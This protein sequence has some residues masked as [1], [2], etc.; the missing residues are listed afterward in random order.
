[1]VEK[2]SKGLEAIEPDDTEL[3]KR[4]LKHDEDAQTTLMTRYYKKVY[5]ISYKFVGKFS[6]AEDLT[7]E[8]FFKVFSQLD[9]YNLDGNFQF[10][11]QR[12]AKN[13][14]ID[15][16]RKTRKEK[17]LLLQQQ[18]EIPAKDD[19]LVDQQEILERKEKM[20]EIL[21]YINDLPPS[22]KDCLVMRDLQGYSYQEISSI[23][24]LPVGTVKSRINRSRKELIDKLKLNEG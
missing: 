4:S 24:N 15:H 18:P 5:N 22:L 12:V 21:S 11:L 13:H 14:C 20:K 1:M 10:W 3:I 8:I 2:K 17:Q 19:N 6:E 23:L 9:K 16:Y 7:Q